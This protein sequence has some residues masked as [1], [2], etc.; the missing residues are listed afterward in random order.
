MFERIAIFKI[1]SCQIHNTIKS[2]AIAVQRL[3]LQG[4][5]K[6]HFHT[7]QLQ[8]IG[9]AIGDG[10]GLIVLTLIFHCQSATSKAFLR[11]AQVDSNCQ[12]DI[13]QL[14]GILRG[15]QADI[16]IRG[17]LFKVRI[18]VRP[19]QAFLIGIQG[20]VDTAQRDNGRGA[21]RHVS[22]IQEGGAISIRTKSHVECAGSDKVFAVRAD[23]LHIGEGVDNLTVGFERIGQFT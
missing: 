2:S 23:N 4:T 14:G 22:I 19:H 12:V 18:R 21:A 16:Q 8:I 1:L 13:H 9:E 11:G 3:G 17:C 20:Q 6:R 10:T 7:R 5:V 15:A